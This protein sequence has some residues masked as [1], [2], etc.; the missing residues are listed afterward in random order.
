M[1]TE[2]TEPTGWT[3][4]NERAGSIVDFRTVSRSP[5]GLEPMLSNCFGGLG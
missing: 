5:S 4:S 2:W 1:W 3:E